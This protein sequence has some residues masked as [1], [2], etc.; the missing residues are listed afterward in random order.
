ML[1]V[2]TG[3]AETQV[4]LGSAFQF[5]VLDMDVLGDGDGDQCSECGARVGKG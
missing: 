1:W 2:E 4:Y 3:E 5:F